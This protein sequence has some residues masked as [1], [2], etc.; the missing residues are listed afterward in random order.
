MT[1]LRNEFLNPFTAQDHFRCSLNFSRASMKKQDSFQKRVLKWIAADYHLCY[2]SLM[3]KVKVIPLPMF[4]QLN[5]L[6]LSE[7]WH[8]NT[9]EIKHYETVKNN[10]R[11]TS[12]KLPTLRTERSRSEFC[13]RTCR[14][15]IHLP[16]YVDFFNPDG[17]KNRLLDYVEL[18]KCL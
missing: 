12:F 3:P 1:E 10:R 8:Q 5:N 4:W 16:H 6:Y 18:H 13:F 15:V 11:H 17:L 2:C 9:G 7:I 14:V